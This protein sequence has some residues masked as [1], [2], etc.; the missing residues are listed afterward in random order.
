MANDK[1]ILIISSSLNE[2]QSKKEIQKSLDKISKEL[3]LNLSSSDA[4]KQTSDMNKLTNAIKTQGKERE[5]ILQYEQ[6]VRYEIEKQTNRQ[7][8]AEKLVTNQLEKQ[9]EKLKLYQEEFSRRSS[10][11]M[12]GQYGGRVDTGA[13]D[14]LKTQV[15]GM[16]VD[17]NNIKASTLQMQQM[18]SQFKNIATSAQ[19][20]SRGVKGF[21]EDL[22]RNLVK[23]GEWMVASTVFYG[24]A[25]SLQY[26]IQAVFELDKALTELKKVVTITDSELKNFVADSYALADALGATNLQL[27]ESVTIFSKMGYALDQATQLGQLAVKLQT[28]GDG[29]GSMED[30]ANSLVAVLKGFGVD[31][32]SAVA[33]T[34]KRVDQLNAVSNA[35]AVSTGDLTAGLQRTSAAMAISGNSFEETTALLT[36]GVEVIRDAEIVARSLSTISQRIFDKGADALKQYGIE[37]TNANGSIRSTY[38]ILTDLHSILP[39]I[40][41][42]QQRWLLSAVSGKEHFKSL[43]AIMQNWG[44]VSETMQVQMNANGSATE[45]LNRK[46]DSLEGRVNKMTNAFS[47]F[48]TSAIDNNL[49]KAGITGIT[50]LVDAF[51][52]LNT[53]SQGLLLPMTAVAI[54]MAKLFNRNIITMLY[55]LLSGMGALTTAGYGMSGAFEVATMSLRTFQITLGIV[56][57]ALVGISVIFN[58]YQKAVQNAKEEADKFKTAQQELNA[59]LSAGDESTK[60]TKEE[61]EALVARYDELSKKVESL[62]GDVLSS[63]GKQISSEYKNASAELKKV[64]DRFQELGLTVKDAESK[65]KLANQALENTKRQSNVVT[66][67]IDH[68]RT[69]IY[70]LVDSYDLLDKAQKQLEEQGYVEQDV[71]EGIS[72]KYGDF[73][74]VTDLSASAILSYTETKKKAIVAQINNEIKLTDETIKNVEI[75]IQALQVEMKAYQELFKQQQASGFEPTLSKEY[76]P[77]KGLL[78][79]LDSDMNALKVKRN[80]LVNATKQ[81]ESIGKD[82]TTS[83]DKDSSS[84]KE[85]IELLTELEKKLRD[86][87][88]QLAIQKSITSSLTEGSK[89][90]NDSIQKEIA[91]LNQRQDLIH[92]Q[93]NAVRGEIA[94]IKAKKQLTD[95]DKKRI[96]ELEE[97]VQSYGQE[98]WS[99]EGT[100]HDINESLAESSKKTAEEIQ[101]SIEETTKKNIETVKDLRELISNMLEQQMKDEIDY[102]E[103]LIKSAKDKLDITLKELEA[104]KELADFTKSRAE[105]EKEVNKLGSKIVSLQTAASQGDMK[106]QAELL[107]L[108][109]ERAKKQE[110]VDELINNRGYELK[111]E[112]LQNQ[113]EAFEANQNKEIDEIEKNLKNA[114][115]MTK[116][117]NERLNMYLSGTHASLFTE[118]INWNKTYGTGIDQDIISK[119]EKAIS[120]IK[121]YNSQLGAGTSATF[122][123]YESSQNKESIIAQMKANGAMWANAS[124]EEKKR[125]NEKNIELARSIGYGYNAQ[126]GKYY[127]NKG[128]LLYDNGGHKPKGT[129]GILGEN[130]EEWVM[131]DKNIMDLSKMAVQQFTQMIPNFSAMQPSL[132]GSGGAPNINVVINGNVD[133]NN[134][135]KITS[136]LKQT[137]VDV[138]RGQLDAF[139]NRGYKPNTR[140][141]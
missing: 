138:S 1:P 39:T 82:K 17:P 60:S 10:K 19:L 15:S 127:N 40:T 24:V 9:R 29:M 61:I 47:K 81:I 23:F 88:H 8:N 103:E 83:K 48:W 35:M 54:A 94:S 118:L 70:G 12:A 92:L 77:T 22:S 43:T 129:L 86:N 3:K 16:S 112:G 55:E 91:L 11:L 95:E 32:N 114:E 65:I 52:S 141:R 75:R 41:E 136:T 25:R 101:K 133:D 64:T 119:W 34:T 28:V 140:I 72:E 125:L 7:V 131:K 102:R 56:G 137:V 106:A 63:G 89:E 98:W 117:V 69:R 68:A 57:A 51:T 21:G 99:L 13:L 71:I 111:K 20:A 126:T 38:D 116:A 120:L 84:T 132:V 124:P 123:G 107:K 85:K 37:T 139:R 115:L 128:E 49:V 96:E 30:T 121:E 79:S 134:I 44:S 76:N 31:E 122:E 36:A 53:A 90:Y 78:K 100:I 4:Q 97:Q 62:R 18:D 66:E 14:S 42:D 50:E 130:V 33:E 45:E 93:A 74:D 26:G 46:L 110:E 59:V 104:E 80:S 58:Q 113:Y 6:K 87:N 2:A 109:D 27:I 108:E 67:A 5:K 105:K 73:I 135:N